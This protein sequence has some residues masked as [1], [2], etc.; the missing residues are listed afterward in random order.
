[1]FEF[2]ERVNLYLKT[3]SEVMQFAVEKWNA[4]PPFFTDSEEE[5]V[6]ERETKQSVNRNDSLEDAQVV[7]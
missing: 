3:A 7:E 5:E 4:L 6:C 2:I 1:M